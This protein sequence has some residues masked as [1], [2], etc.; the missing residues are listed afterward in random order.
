LRAPAVHLGA[1]QHLVVN[2]LE[3]DRMQLVGDTVTQG[4]RLTFAE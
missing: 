4:Q 3:V 1:D 2:H